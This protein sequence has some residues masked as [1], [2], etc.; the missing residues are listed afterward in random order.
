MTSRVVFFTEGSASIGLG[1]ITRCLSIAQAFEE[2]RVDCRF[3]IQ[4]DD[5]VLKIKD[6]QHLELQNWIGFSDFRS[7][8]NPEDIAIVDSYIAPLEIYKKI[9]QTGVLMLCVDDFFRIDY[10]DEAI[11]LNGTFNIEQF[12]NRLTF[13]N[14]LLGSQFIPLRKP[15]WKVPVRS[16]TASLQSVLVTFGGEDCR[17][18]TAPVVNTLLDTFPNLQI[19]AV[20][21]AA[22]QSALPN[23]HPRLKIHR[24][25]SAAQMCDLMLQCDV[26]VSAA[27]QTLYELACTGCPTVAVK[28][29]NNQTHNFDGA[30]ALGVLDPQCAIDASCLPTRDVIASVARAVESL[31]CHAKRTQLTAN[32]Q[33]NVDGQGARRVAEVVL[34]QAH[35]CCHRNFASSH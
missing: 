32:S 22:Y 15:F 24:N 17:Q 7:L 29:A 19:H 33:R 34:S 13:K 16:C 25:L 11:V 12:A 26:A 20:I 23:P 10:P 14:A 27:G 21:G 2:H 4:G 35:E 18:L 9:A 3:V 31:Q 30:L 5:H 6:L 1:H 8:L 28:I